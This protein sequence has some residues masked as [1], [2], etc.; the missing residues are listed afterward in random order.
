MT[1]L[2]T[3]KSKILSLIRNVRLALDLTGIKQSIN[4][5]LLFKNQ[6]DYRKKVEYE[7]GFPHFT[8]GRLIC[9]GDKSSI[10]IPCMAHS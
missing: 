1:N 6:E 5:L 7:T 10:Y 2:Y 9:F 3:K 4:L 8:V